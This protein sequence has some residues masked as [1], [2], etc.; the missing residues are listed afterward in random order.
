MYSC[1]V[2]HCMEYPKSTNRKNWAV[3]KPNGWVELGAIGQ[4]RRRQ[5]PFRLQLRRAINGIAHAFDFRDMQ[6][7]VVPLHLIPRGL[8]KARCLPAII[9]SIIRLRRWTLSIIP[10]NRRV[11]FSIQDNSC[12][13]K[14]WLVIGRP[15][16]YSQPRFTYATNSI[17][18]ER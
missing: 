14:Y 10:L 2:S 11:N 17:A 12:T 3:A 18:L 15:R 5:E 8:V 13:L 1:S 6:Q 4:W 7:V 16:Y 9:R